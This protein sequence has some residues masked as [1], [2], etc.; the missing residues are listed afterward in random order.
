MVP[1]HAVLQKSHQWL[2]SASITPC[3]VHKY[4]STGRKSIPVVMGA[5]L[6][7]VLRY[8]IH[9]KFNVFSQLFFI[10]NSEKFRKPTHIVFYYSFMGFYY[11]LLGLTTVFRSFSLDF[12]KGRISNHT[13]QI[14][15]KPTKLLP[16]RIYS[17]LTP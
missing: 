6:I 8:N 17:G 16:L 9:D 1:A 5:N 4:L 12:C 10:K 3:G 7:S 11:F 15:L 14:S 13:L 2:W